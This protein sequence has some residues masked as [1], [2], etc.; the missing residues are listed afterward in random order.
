MEKKV[1]EYISKKFDDEIF[2]PVLDIDL[3]V[4]GKFVDLEFL[5]NID[6]LK[7]FGMSNEQPV[8]C[9]EIWVCLMLIL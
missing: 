8:F 6:K 9:P 3:E 2:M 1:S 5:E 7:P 4:P